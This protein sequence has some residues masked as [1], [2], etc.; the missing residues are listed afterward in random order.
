MFNFLKNIWI[1]IKYPL[2]RSPIDPLTID[3]DYG[4]VKEYFL[5]YPQKACFGYDWYEHYRVHL[6]IWKQQRIMAYLLC[7]LIVEFLIKIWLD[8]H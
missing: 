1:K 2:G 3:Y 5:E 7:L 8:F 4:H 6:S